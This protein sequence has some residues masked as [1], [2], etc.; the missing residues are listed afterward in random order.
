M[1][2]PLP[3]F[4][5]GGRD[6]IEMEEVRNVISSVISKAIKA[7]V[8]ELKN[9]IDNRLDKIIKDDEKEKRISCP[10]YFK[11]DKR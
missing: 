5:F 8:E 11:N 9:N 2:Y 10:I 7:G 6:L 3:T 1:E 4:I